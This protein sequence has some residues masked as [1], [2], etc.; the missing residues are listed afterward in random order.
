MVGLEPTLSLLLEWRMQSSAEAWKCMVEEMSAELCVDLSGSLKYLNVYVVIT[1]SEIQ[2]F[3]EGLW[4][5]TYREFD[6]G[7]QQFPLPNLAKSRPTLRFRTALI[8]WNE[9]P[10]SANILMCPLLF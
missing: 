9:R 1:P 4:I 7:L 5:S 8:H 2:S 3:H 10:I 6:I